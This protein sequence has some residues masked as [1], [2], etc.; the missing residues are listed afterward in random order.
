MKIVRTSAFLAS[1]AAKL[2]GSFGELRLRSI[3][4]Y[5]ERTLPLFLAMSSAVAH[6]RPLA[7]FSEIPP[8]LEVSEKKQALAA[9]R[10]HVTK[11]A[12]AISPVP[13]MF[14]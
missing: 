4:R 5:N 9:H 12:I 6:I 1:L 14:T 7:I 10:L 2:S 8:T 13:Q 3:W 11:T